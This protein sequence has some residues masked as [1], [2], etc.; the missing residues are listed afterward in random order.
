MPLVVA[1]EFARSFPPSS[2]PQS[3]SV[4]LL[5]HMFI[6]LSLLS[7]FY[8]LLLL[9][10]LFPYFLLL[11]T[12]CEPTER[13]NPSLIVKINGSR[14]FLHATS[15]FRSQKRAESMRRCSMRALFYFRTH[16]NR[17]LCFWPLLDDDARRYVYLSI[18]RRAYAI[19]KTARDPKLSI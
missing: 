9:L 10:G 3:L 2:T 6:C 5:S 18:C 19:Y 17:C 11:E 8:L 16:E 7:T 1:V 12:P 13:F 15:S 14:S 4:T